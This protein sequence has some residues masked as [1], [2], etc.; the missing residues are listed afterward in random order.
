MNCT[1]YL[2]IA[3]ATASCWQINGML[4]YFKSWERVMCEALESKDNAKID[5]V[6]P[7]FTDSLHEKYMRIKELDQ[8]L[9]A[10]EVGQ[11]FTATAQEF[12]DVKADKQ[13]QMCLKNA[14]ADLNKNSN[15]ITQRQQAAITAYEGPLAR[16]ALCALRNGR[17]D[18]AQELFKIGVNASGTYWRDTVDDQEIAIE[19][20]FTQALRYLGNNGYEFT[21]EDV[22]TMWSTFAKTP[23]D[24]TDFFRHWHSDVSNSFNPSPINPLSKNAQMLRALKELH[25][26]K[27]T[28]KEKTRTV[29]Q[30]S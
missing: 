28:E 4:Y 9:L 17:V 11:L 13:T 16:I 24:E 19:R 5:A 18:I 29:R 7:G 3:L 10:T 25:D 8:E 15:A 21:L 22:K 14:E 1:K 30:K 26:Q 20:G 12:E 23:I 27:R 2:L 6:W